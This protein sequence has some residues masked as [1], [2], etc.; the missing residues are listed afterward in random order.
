MDAEVVSHDH[1]VPVVVAEGQF[2]AHFFREHLQV[3][4]LFDRLRSLI[5]EELEEG[6]RFKDLFLCLV[7]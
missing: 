3:R 7:N 1:E 2:C 5:V 6:E 4:F